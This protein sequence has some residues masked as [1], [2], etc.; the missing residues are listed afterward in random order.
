[1]GKKAP[2]SHSW[3]QASPQA[4]QIGFTD[5]LLNSPKLND[6]YLKL[7]ATDQNFFKI[8]FCFGVQFM[9]SNGELAFDLRGHS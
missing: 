9:V 3:A 2:G 7:M 5:W 1:M 4:E 8:F 6:S